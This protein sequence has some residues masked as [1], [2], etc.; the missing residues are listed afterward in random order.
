MDF[1]LDSGKIF[2]EG[3][4]RFLLPGNVVEIEHDVQY[5]RHIV[6]QLFSVLLKIGGMGIEPLHDA[7]Q[8][9]DMGIV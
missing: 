5:L 2:H 9:A 1:L 3:R 7:G 6:L 4:G 8:D